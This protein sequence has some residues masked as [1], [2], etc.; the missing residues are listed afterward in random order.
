MAE[1]QEFW[2]QIKAFQLD[3]TR[4]KKVMERFNGRIFSQDMSKIYGERVINTDYYHPLMFTQKFKEEAKGWNLETKLVHMTDMVAYDATGIFQKGKVVYQD[5][6][7]KSTLDNQRALN[8]ADEYKEFLEIIGSLD[9]FPPPVSENLF[10][11]CTNYY[12]YV[13]WRHACNNNDHL[14]PDNW[15][16]LHNPLNM[17]RTG[18]LQV[19]QL[20]KGVYHGFSEEGLK[21]LHKYLRSHS[22]PIQILLHEHKAPNE[23]DYLFEKKKGEMR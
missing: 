5:E 4:T 14:V 18:A 21:N 16:M 15:R 20:Q 22:T 6:A 12:D 19:H 10:V 13:I 8:V 2:E 7:Y 9:I 23:F 17:R 11:F 1:S 3:K